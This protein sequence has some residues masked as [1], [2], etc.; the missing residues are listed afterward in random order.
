MGMTWI[1][2]VAGGVNATYDNFFRLSSLNINGAN[3][4]S[5]AY[6]NDGLLT[7][8]G[9]LTLTRDQ[10]NGRLTGTTLGTVNDAWTYTGFGEAQTYTA[11]ASGSLAFFM[12]LTRDNAAASPPKPRRLA[13]SP[14]FMATRTTPTVGG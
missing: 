14:A 4:V 9:D 12:S 11:S 7:Q 6:D 5:Y 10:H 13:A 3:P 1:G 8:A 2:P